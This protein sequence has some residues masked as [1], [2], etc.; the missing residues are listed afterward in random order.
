MRCR[1]C[2]Y[3]LWTVTGRSCPECG[4][5]FRPSEFQF[6]PNSVRFECPH[7]RAGY[8]GTTKEGHLAP[9]AFNCTECAK[10]IDMDEMVLTPMPGCEAISESHLRNP[11]LDRSGSTTAAWLRSAWQLVVRPSAFATSLRHGGTRGA[12]LGFAA[13]GWLLSLVVF[14]P[15][16][17]LLQ[18]S[19][20]FFSPFSFL[21]MGTIDPLAIVAL[22]SLGF[23]AFLLLA[24]VL[25]G[26]LSHVMLAMLAP[27]RGTAALSVRS[28]LYVSGVYAPLFA[29]QFA[30]PCACLCLPIAGVLSCIP[31][32]CL[33]REFHRTST[34][35]ALTAAAA[36]WLA[37][38]LTCAGGFV[39]MSYY[40]TAAAAT[41]M[42][43]L[44]PANAPATATVRQQTAAAS[45]LMQL[46]YAGSPGA[47]DP[48]A[49]SATN[50]F[51][52][53][54]I[55]DLIT[56]H[57]SRTVSLAG[58]DIASL[59]GSSASQMNAMSKSL[60]AAVPTNAPYRIGS[61]VLYLGN[62][63][64][65][66]SAWHA[67][68]RDAQGNYHV[69]ATFMEVSMDAATFERYVRSEQARVAAMGGS[70]PH[71][72]DV[73]D[74]ADA[75]DPFVPPEI[76][77]EVDAEGPPASEDEPDEGELD[78]GEPDEGAPD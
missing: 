32:T 21:F 30:A 40:A 26:L 3:P 68:W 49:S 28:S 57:G 43:T 17:Y 62:A 29:V 66:T 58:T 11:W 41:A 8:I 72:N 38:F 69:A 19:G 37:I 71:P 31:M 76:I 5:S 67:V 9:R 50:S 45:T 56:E 22:A 54:T 55:R 70:M 35:R 65:D 24:S 16:L 39:A 48:F 7:C 74:A 6:P 47:R 36:P 64:G 15:L 20:A 78:E 63:T 4:A 60:L 46:A 42:A 53:I 73:K 52:W 25:M 61:L 2:D 33:L 77:R 75:T 44:G 27:T 12:A 18:R 10:P 1:T 59:D 51:V 34:V 14:A 23:V 13:I